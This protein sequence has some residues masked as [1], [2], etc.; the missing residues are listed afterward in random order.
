[1][2]EKIEMKPRQAGVTKLPAPEKVPETK[3][4]TEKVDAKQ[5]QKEGK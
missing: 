4:A 1:M 5:T 3:Q 2:S